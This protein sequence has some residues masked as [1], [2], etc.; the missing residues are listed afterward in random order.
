MKTAICFDLDGTITKQEILPLIAREIDLEDEISILTDATIRGLIPFQKSFRLRCRLLDSVPVSRVREIVA[1]TELNLPLVEFIN[2]HV[3]QCFVVS[4]NLDI[5]IEPLL[6]KIG[7]QHYVSTAQMENDRLLTISKVLD[8]STAINH[9][10]EKF[11]KIIVVGEG[12]NDVPMFELADV[13]IAYGGVHP[14][15]STVIQLSN[16]VVFDGVSLC[17]LLKTLL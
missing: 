13:G 8:K 12:M 1:N 2:T 14:P 17:K 10:R 3:E 7:C 4:G 6:T 16:Y 15:N 5:W 9:L 11:E